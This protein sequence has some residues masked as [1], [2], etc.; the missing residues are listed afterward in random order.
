MASQTWPANYN[1]RFVVN[2]LHWP[3][4]YAEGGCLF[5]LMTTAPFLC[6]ELSSE[7]E[8]EG[9]NLMGGSDYSRN[10]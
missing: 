1:F 8:K 9:G 4:A 7:A 5:S 3:I 6:Q 2:R 10:I